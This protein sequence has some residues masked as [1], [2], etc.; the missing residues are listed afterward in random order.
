MN[1]IYTSAAILGI[2][3]VLSEFSPAVYAQPP[4]MLITQQQNYQVTDNILRNLR[5]ATDPSYADVKLQALNQTITE[6]QGSEV[7]RAVGEHKKASIGNSHL[8]QSDYTQAIA[9]FN[10]ALKLQPND[11]VAYY[12]RGVAY[13]KQGNYTQAIADYNQALNLQPNFTDTY[14]SRGVAYAREGNYTQAIADYNQALKLQPNDANAYYNKACAYSLKKEVKA[15]I[16]NLQ[17]AIDL[18]AKYREYALTDS[19]FD[20]IRQDKQFR[21]LVGQ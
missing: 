7:A 6:Q 18:D 4:Q 16:E 14:V 15:A 12:N 3:T 5:N 20:N 17:R 11:A 2:F 1:H 10:Q 21:V 9:D 19:D 8:F 13:I